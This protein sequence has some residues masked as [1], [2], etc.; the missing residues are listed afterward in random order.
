MLKEFRKHPTDYFFLMMYYIILMVWY[1]STNE[2]R[3]VQWTAAIAIGLGHVVWG[4]WHHQ[5]IKLL[6]NRIIIEY[7]SAG[8]FATVILI[9]ITL[10]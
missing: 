3:V 2:M 6:T 9:L 8:L 1:L 10:Q 5:R 7:C 4:V